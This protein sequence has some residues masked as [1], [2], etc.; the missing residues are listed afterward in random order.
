MDLV[1]EPDVGAARGQRPVDE[2]HRRLYQ[3]GG[4]ALDPR[5]HRRPLGRS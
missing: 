4:R 2:D 1:D 3:I 5:V